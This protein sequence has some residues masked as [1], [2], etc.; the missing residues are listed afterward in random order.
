MDYFVIYSIIFIFVF[1][2]YRIYFYFKKKYR[3]GKKIMEII[4]LESKYKLNFKKEEY[5]GLYT[6]IS[7][8]NSF[9][10]V[11]GYAIINFIDVLLFKIIIVMLVTIIL[12][13]LLYMFLGHYYKSRRWL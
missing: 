5:R 9:I 12:I 2:F 4:Y 7:I 8:V 10:L 13:Y 3:P 1:I 11:V 6:S